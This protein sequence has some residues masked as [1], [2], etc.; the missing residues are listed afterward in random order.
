VKRVASTTGL[1]ALVAIAAACGGDSTTT[2]G[3]STVEVTITDEGCNPFELTIEPGKTTFHVTNDGADRIS[4]FEVLT[5]AGKIIGEKESLAP[6]L[7]GSF[8]LDLDEGTYVLA[9]PGGTTHPTGTLTVGTAHGGA[10]HEATGCVP[11]GDP[12]KATSRVAATLRDFEIRLAD[13]SVAGG[14]VAIEAKNAGTHPHEIV[15]VKGVAP[16]DLPHDSTGKVDEGQLAAGAV[17]GELEAFNPGLSCA[18]AFDLDPGTYTLFC[19]VVGPE[20]A[21]EKLGMVAVL[22]V[23]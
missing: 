4:E 9:C 17:I 12:S 10:D 11:S 20:G 14:T 3:S 1:F 5:E 23:S 8:T 15:V 7:D 2:S 6:G 22:A 19:N 16:A 21:H 18:A 13:G